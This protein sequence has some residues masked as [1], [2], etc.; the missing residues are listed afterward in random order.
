MK[1]KIIIKISRKLKSVK[2]NLTLRAE[3]LADFAQTP[4][5]ALK[6]SLENFRASYEAGYM[7]GLFYHVSDNG[8]DEH[9][10]VL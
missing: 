8:F 5:N 4:P 3:D 10:L 7:R 6:L 1:L 2:Q 9:A